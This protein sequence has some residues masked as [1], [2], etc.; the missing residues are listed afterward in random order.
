VSL[1]LSTAAVGVPS[2]CNFT[3][4]QRQSGRLAQWTGDFACSIV[5]GL[6]GRGEDIA[7][8]SRRGTFTLD[9]VAITA[10]G[11]RGALTASDQDCTMTGHLGGTRLP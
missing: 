8:T 5:I 7:R 10:D 3:G 6:D 2:T 1:A 11:F 9:R 4:I